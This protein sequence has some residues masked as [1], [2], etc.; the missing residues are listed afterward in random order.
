M[1][2]LPIDAVLADLTHALVEHNQCLV[3]APPGAGKS[4]KLPLHLLQSGVISGKIVL[5]EPRRLAARSIAQFLSEQLGEPLGQTVG[6]CMRGE[7]LASEQTCLEVVTEGVMTRWLQEDPTLEG[8]DLIIFDEFHER[9]LHAD[10]ALAF[11]LETQAALRDDL[12]LLIMSATLSTEALSAFLPKAPVLTSEGRSFPIEVRY[13]P[14]K[15]N[16]DLVSG[17]SRQVRILLAEETGSILVFLPTMKAIRDVQADLMGVEAQVVPL[18][19]QLELATQR[20]AIAPSPVGSRK[21]VL[22]TNIAETSLTIEGI[23]IVVDSGLERVALWDAKSGLT[24]LETRLIGQSSA[25]QRAGRAGRLEAGICV[26]LYSEAVFVRQPQAIAPEILRSDLTGVMLEMAQWGSIAFSSDY[27]LDTP[28]T[29][30]IEQTQRQLIR[31]KALDEQGRLTSLGQRM[32]QFGTE[33][34]LAMMLASAQQSQSADRCWVASVLASLLEQPPKAAQQDVRSLF[35]MGLQ[36]AYRQRAQRYFSQ[37]LPKGKIPSVFPEQEVLPALLSGFADWVARSRHDGQGRYQ[38]ACGQGAK[39]W[40]DS[41][42]SG[43][44]WLLVLSMTQL[45]VGESN[46]FLALPISLSA[47][48]A[49]GESHFHHQDRVIWDEAKGKVIAERCR[50]FGELV[51]QKQAIAQPS[52]EQCLQGVLAAVRKRGLSALNLHDATQQW[53]IRARCVIEWLNL[54]NVP[55]LS[56]AALLTHLDDWLAPFCTSVRSMKDLQK[57][58]MQDAL[59]AYVGWAWSSWLD[60]ALPTHFVVPTGNCIALRYE[61]G[62]APVLSVRLQEM[63]GQTESPKLAEGQVSV[64]VELLSPARRPLQVTQDLAAFWKGAYIEV[65]KEMKGRYPKH[66][67]PDDPANHQPTHLTKKALAKKG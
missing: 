3:Q 16:R 61:V 47:L 8:I 24:R 29:A 64:V 13:A 43:E 60:T 25:I 21:V 55:D 62:K 57:V 63:F 20:E 33:P 36:G 40:Q 4:T 12:R 26:R 45:S 11:A 48:E 31:L 5:L 7:R 19:G 51:I 39:L 38:L 50:C 67:W 17:V 66:V 35:S 46:V 15:D 65:K 59:D 22:A 49:E 23:R 1:S 6:L 9:S 37:L 18:H 54:T 53:L 14:L 56:D 27:W 32:I 28:S 2:Q 34:R 52:D 44:D 30:Q 58:K 42:L 41:A 10:T